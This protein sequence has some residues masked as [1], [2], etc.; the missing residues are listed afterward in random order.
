MFEELRTHVEDRSRGEEA[1]FLLCGFGRTADRV[2]LIAR[3]W[4][5]VPQEQ[6]VSRNRGYMVEWSAAFNGSAINQAD[7]VGGAMVLVHSHGN[8]SRPVLSS[9]DLENASRLFPAA[10]RILAGRPSGSIVIGEEAASGCFWIDGKCA[11]ILTELK[12]VGVPIRKW[13]PDPLAHTQRTSARRRLDRQ[14]RALGNES[15]RL[16]RD[17]VVGVVGNSGGGS[18]CCQQLAHI[19]VGTIVPID[20]Q[21]VDETNR[22]RMIGSESQDVDTTLKVDA[23]E[24]MIHRI[25]ES[26]H[27]A[28]VPHKF[29]H[30]EVLAA[31]KC[32][33]VVVSC[34]DSF[35]VR[36][37]LNT[38]CR[39]YHVPLV[40]IG[41]NIRTEHGS[42][43]AAH[44]QVVAVVPDSPCAR[45]TPLLSDAVLDRE[46]AERPPGYDLNPNAGDPQVVSMNGTLASEACN[47]VL[48]LLTGY[49]CGKRVPGWWSYDGRSGG[50]IRSDLP[51]A[52]SACPACAEFAHADPAI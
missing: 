45:C 41:L 1:G 16:L 6:I 49:S 22:G 39:R 14:S 34:V 42:L 5:P 38:F 26:I 17:A 37:Q 15:D 11:G 47:C 8:T 27:V 40:D 18:H 50:L 51:A 44:G 24:R 46:R 48:D 35:L 20:G 12:I 21:T 25:D 9:D 13:V 36:E 43:M 28:K 3:R 29:P 23:M 32:A 19:G 31:L 52:W 10:S 33:D 7:E 4:L 2:I 30:P